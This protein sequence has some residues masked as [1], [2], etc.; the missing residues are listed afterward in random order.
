MTEFL[1]VNEFAKDLKK[2]R[3]KFRNIDRDLEVFCKALQSELP[4]QLPGTVQISG[5]GREIS[6]PIFKVRHFR[7]RDLKRGSRSC[8]RIIYAFHSDRDEVMLIEIYYKGDKENEDHERIKRYFT[9][10][11]AKASETDF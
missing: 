8:I 2:L 1:Q 6:V 10:K 5:L 7:S 4:N 3:K 11:P 9:S